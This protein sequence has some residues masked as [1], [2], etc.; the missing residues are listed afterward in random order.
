MT[1]QRPSLLSLPMLL[2]A[3][4]TIA[5]AGITAPAVDAS[6]PTSPT[7][8]T[9]VR[10]LDHVT[11]I[12]VGHPPPA[13]PVSVGVPGVPL[14][15]L[16]S[17]TGVATKGASGMAGVRAGGGASLENLSASEALRIQNAANKIGQPISVVGSRAGGTSGALSDWDYVIT[18]ANSRTI[19]SV[20]NSLPE[21][22]RGIGDPRNID[23]FRGSLNTD[24]PYITFYPATP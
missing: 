1:R 5:V 23:I 9:R 22:V 10:A 20:R 16:V 11:R 15:Q 18:G 7:A 13:T 14:R 6:A 17:A 24:S 4:L 2:A 19:G 12:A 3:I 8:E 21:G